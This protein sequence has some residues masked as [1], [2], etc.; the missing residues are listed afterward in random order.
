[1]CD[2]LCALPHAA[3]GV[4]LFAKNSDRPPQEAQ[5]LE[6]LPARV[7][8]GMT[9]ATYVALPALAE[10]TFGVLGSRP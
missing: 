3:E 10:P 9:R 4:T 6:W 7:D 5:L 2:L 8:E 1:M